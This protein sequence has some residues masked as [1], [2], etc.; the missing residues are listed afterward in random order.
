MDE[1]KFEGMEGIKIKDMK[2]FIITFFVLFLLNLVK[3]FELESY[4]KYQLFFGMIFMILFF[5]LFYNYLSAKSD[6]TILNNSFVIAAFFGI[7]YYFTYKFTNV[8]NSDSN[9]VVHH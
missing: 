1:L 3:V 9:G 2:L 7:W 6:N 5:G 8:Y 4:Q